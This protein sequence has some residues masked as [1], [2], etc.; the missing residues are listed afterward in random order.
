MIDNFRYDLTRAIEKSSL[1]VEIRERFVQALSSE[2]A[3]SIM[4][5]VVQKSDYSIK[6]CLALYYEIS[7]ESAFLDYPDFIYSHLIKLNFPTL[8]DDLQDTSE[9]KQEIKTILILYSVFCEF[10]KNSD[11]DAFYVKYPI[12]MPQSDEIKNTEDRLEYYTFENVFKRKYVYEL[13]RL[14]QEVTPFNSLDHISGVFCVAINIARQLLKVG[15]PVNLGRVAGAAACHDIGKF[16]CIGDNTKRVPYLHYY[17]SDLW[18][19]DNSLFYMGNIAVNHS[20]WDLEL[21]TLSLE[22]LIL[23]YS[24]FR[25]KNR[26]NKLGRQEMHLFNLDDSFDV[27]LN[28]LDDV[29][30][31]KENRYKRVYA[32]LLDF[33]KY[34]KSK[35]IG[36]DPFD[37][38]GEPISK[39]PIVLLGQDEIVSYYKE[40]SIEKNIFLMANLSTEEGFNRILDNAA[41]ETDGKVL[42]S[43]LNIFDE[44]YAYLESGQKLVT[45]AFLYNLLVNKDEDV[46]NHAADLMGKIIGSYDEEYR[47]ELPKDVI[48]APFEISSAS[49]FKRYFQQM[50]YPDHKIVDLHIEWIR[51][52]VKI[53][54]SSLFKSA[55]ENTRNQLFDIFQ[56][57]LT[58]TNIWDDCAIYLMQ[59]IKHINFAFFEN[60][61]LTPTLEFIEAGISSTDVNTSLLTLDSTRVA[62]L[63]ML[64]KDENRKKAAKMISVVDHPYEQAPLNY[65]K[66]KTYKMMNLGDELLKKYENFSNP[67]ELRTEQLFLSNLRSATPWVVKKANIEIVVDAENSV[68]AKSSLQTAM[69]LCNL[70]KVSSTESV[71]NHA[72]KALINIMKSLTLHEKNEICVELIRALEMQEY[73]FTRYIPEYLGQ[74]LLELSPTEIN[75]I[76]NDFREKIKISNWQ[77]TILVLR[78]VGW[79]LKYFEHRYQAES[80]ED[81]K[82]QLKT[83]LGM[84]LNGV[85]SYDKFVKHEAF[86]VIGREVLGAKTITIETKHQIFR[87]LGKKLLYAISKMTEEDV[88]FINFSASLNS[89]YRFILEYEFLHGEIK[90]RTTKKAAFFPGTFD[91]FT[92]SHKQ[93]A[94][95]IR[96]MGYSVYLAVDEFSWSKRTQANSLRRM[97]MEMSVADEMD[98]FIYPETDQ[99]NISSPIDLK[100]LQDSFSGEDVYMVVGSDVVKNASSYKKEK[101]ENSI[102]TFNH[103]IFERTGENSIEDAEYLDILTSIDAK[104]QRLTLPAQYKDISSTQ[105]RSYIDNNNDISQ[106]VDPMAQKFIYEMGLYLKEQQFKKSLRTKRFDIEYIKNPTV[107]VLHEL[108]REHKGDSPAYHDAIDSMDFSDIQLAVSIRDTVTK[109]LYA[110]SILN[111][112]KSSMY[113]ANFKDHEV[114]ERLRKDASGRIALIR[115][116][117]INRGVAPANI[118][119]ILLTEVLTQC[120]SKD[121]TYAVYK[122]LVHAENPTEDMLERQGFIR[123]DG[124]TEDKSI[125]LVNISS[126]CILFL[127]FMTKLKEPFNTNAELSAVVETTRRRLQKALT[128]LHKGSL[129]LA[130]DNDVLI[131]KL[132]EMICEQ[133]E[134]TTQISEPR[135]LGSKMCVPFGSV[136]N[137]STVPNTVTKSLHS[138][139]MYDPDLKNFNVT[140]S[141]Y[142][143][144]LESQVKMLGSFQR[145][146]M[147]I[148]DLLHKGYRMKAL[149]PLFEKEGL[150]V[151]LIVSILTGKGKEIM[152]MQGRDVNSSYFLPNLKYWFYE[153]AM[154]PFVYGD[155]INRTT[156][157]KR[158]ML[159]SINFIL[160]YC[161]PVFLADCDNKDV[162]ELSKVCIENAM[163]LFK[164]IEAEY[165]KIYDKNFTLK[166]LGEVFVSPYCP[167]LGENIQHDVNLRPTEYLANDLERMMRIESLVT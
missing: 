41:S 115:G 149:D 13:M 147:I 116:L 87:L 157:P 16:A 3:Q 129:V 50:L 104:V 24:D 124:E 66:Y 81:Y 137:S 123:I 9:K 159:P 151:E 161:M 44:Y 146:I 10:E 32:K 58:E 155:S 77:V 131:D 117:F 98:I 11:C 91:P 101:V 111:W 1:D 158:Y 165:Q 71:R 144:D 126:P 100:R 65:L 82:E 164:C 85:Y 83:M 29:D 5:Q 84:L 48:I 47:K 141:P 138:V 43:Y 15:L 132:L 72:G 89:I 99:I 17:F 49:L 119:Q 106:F 14:S 120:I 69:H 62:Y 135:I 23:I 112:L 19:K 54:I 39:K 7:G 105:I 21:E 113:Y 153:K 52:N 25:V 103:V 61:N 162:F 95:C 160:P 30:I 94:R 86:R 64:D 59:S 140:A 114:C 96:D 143:L 12:I 78:T 26:K 102:H 46:R 142:Y 18:Y 79:T 121:Y 28:M 75:E 145:P 127:D 97:I 35:G 109:K 92:L 6:N 37:E 150:D 163:T 154:Y 2:K 36:V 125:Y 152:D 34:M 63:R 136:L 67:S 60:K 33:E 88:V 56:E 57:T 118:E 38:M 4:T 55:T 107:D 74:I 31:A 27:I 22:S 70:L 156:N 167:D 73:Q 139:K 68:G 42:R 130:F 45:L 108:I 40:L 93:I 90:M 166:Q 134:V 128:K 122:P 76:F 53:M 51:L 148:D 8:A 110:F 20:T 80:E 133:N